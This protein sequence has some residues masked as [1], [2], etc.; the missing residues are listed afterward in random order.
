[1]AYKN[2]T[3]QIRSNASN[4]ILKGIFMPNAST[5]ITSIKGKFFL[6]FFLFLTKKKGN[7]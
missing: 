4:K 6:I 7:V 3:A 2:G 5:I 1:M